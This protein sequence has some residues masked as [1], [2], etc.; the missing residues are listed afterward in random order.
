MLAPVDTIQ[1]TK[2]ASTSG[3]IVD[4][5]SPAG[6]IAPVRLIPT[7]TSS[8]SIRSAN[9]RHPSA[10]RPALYARNAWSTSSGIVSRPVIG[11]GSMRCP[12]RKSLRV[13]VASPAL[14]LGLAARGRERMRTPLA[15][16]PHD[17]HRLP[18]AIGDGEELQIGR[19]DLAFSRH[20]FPQPLRE[21]LPIRLAEQDHRKMLHFPG[22]DQ[23]QRLEQ[24]V[25]G[26][27][28]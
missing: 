6:V 3:M 26:A 24:L 20:P 22:L 25:H 12:R 7:V 27:V 18:R 19:G 11:F 5:P 17:R 8:S 28:P 1:S 21:P 9:S 4:M 14:H 16:L 13:I 10:S 23:R 15:R 2:P